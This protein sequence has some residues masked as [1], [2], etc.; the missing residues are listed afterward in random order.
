LTVRRQSLVR[1]LV[2]LV[3]SAVASGLAVSALLATWQEVERYADARR[4]LMLA[5]ARVFAAATARPVAE[6]KQQETLEAIRA[7]G[8]IPGFLFVQV[9]TPDG[10]VLAALGGASRLSTDPSLTRE[11]TP[12]ILDLLRGGTILI[13]VPVID[14]GKEVGRINLISDTADL[15]PRLLSTLWLT[16]VGSL[17]A[18]VVG[19]LIAWRFQRAITH[20]LRR[21]LGA[22]QEVQADHRYDVH[23][24]EAADQEIGLLVDGFNAM[25]GA[26]RER[27]QHLT[28]YRETLEQKVVDRTRELASARDAAEQANRAKSDFVATM[29]HEIR[30]PMNGIMVMA[31]LL[32]NADIPRR[33]HR[34]AEVIATSGRSL[35][36]I[37]NDILDFSKIEAGKLELENGQICLDEVVENVTSLF[38]ERARA[39]NIDLAAAI[40]PDVPRTISGDPVRLSQVISNLVNNALKFTESGFVRITVKTCPADSRLIDVLVE[41]TGIGIP[42]EK[43]STIFEVFTQADQNTNRKYGGTGLGLAICRRIVTAMGGDVDVVSTLGV[44]SKFR[45][46]IPTGATISRPWPTIAV[47]SAGQLAC[48]IDVSGEAT[49]SALSD[50]LDAFGY[51][52]RRTEAGMTIGDYA[53]AALVCVDAERLDKLPARSGRAQIVVAVTQFGDETAENIVASG[54]ADAAISRPLLRSEIEELLRRI[55][56]GEKRLHDQA[57]MRRRDGPL[58]EFKNLRVLVADDNAVNREVAT[59]ALSR[60]GARVDTAENGAEAV[61]AAAKHAHDIIL[62]DGSMP[63]MDGFAAARII[64]QAEEAEGRDRIPIVALTAHVIGAAAEE[65]RLAGMNAVMH[66]PFTIAQLAYCLMEQVPEF[67]TLAGEPIGVNDS[68]SVE[69]KLEVGPSRDEADF[70]LV[71]PAA[72]GQFRALDDGKKDSFLR[73]VIDLYTEHAPQAYAQLRQHAKNGEVEA[74]GALA[75][76]L[77]S[78][79]L[80]IGA[81]EVAKAAAGFEQWA[82]GEGHVPNPDALDALSVTLERTL[83]VL[84]GRIGLEPSSR[85]I[86]GSRIPQAP[87]VPANSLERDLF[88]AIER[89]ELD[90]EYQPIV[91]RSGQQVLGVEALVRWRKGGMDNVPPSIFVPEAERSGFIHEIGE[92]VLRRACRDALAWPRL[93][94]AINVSPVQFRRAGLADRLEKILAESGIDPGRIELEITET[95]LLDAEAAVLTTMEQLHRRSVSFALDDFGTG[96]ACLTSL[97]RFPFDKIKIDRSFVSNVGSTID[98]T[99]VHAVVSIGRALGLKVVAEGVETV[100]HQKFVATAGV[101]AMQGYLFA[102]PMKGSDVAGFVAEF[103]DR[104]RPPTVAAR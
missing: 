59:E 36:S 11:E 62:M 76:S 44:G 28:A 88:L 53:S 73:R 67:R 66:K 24:D 47:K 77:K 74:C 63:Q 18:I 85:Q 95:A 41:D 100:E 102:R 46:R 99:I 87:I 19:L 42:P 2:L 48:I 56:V 40:D 9:R 50:Y 55:A 69:R 27:D 58:P 72:L 54:A 12:S 30:T 26:I 90:V 34:Y 64:R 7:I 1:K 49:A 81:V 82:R 65:W 15:W 32:A 91:D 78:M 101:H 14:G 16:L 94:V 8:N 83:A 6:L 23:V 97:R 103:H 93:A 17:A 43:L 57:P 29:S 13:T 68:G 35:L 98:A 104:V 45:V 96:Y 51:R 37:I 4:Q 86:D 89:Q 20:P 80:N 84:A 52:V 38:A 75:H 21:L 79:S 70:P 60:L 10:R 92:W 61:A 33:L 25:L 22:M 5:T 71:D 31:D 3:M 39:R